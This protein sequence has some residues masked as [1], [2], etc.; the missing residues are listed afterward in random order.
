[1]PEKDP[2]NYTFIT[3][4]WVIFLSTWGGL[5]SFLRK[6]K[7]GEAKASNIMELIGELV[8]SSFAGMITFFLCQ[9]AGFDGVT[10]AALVGISGHMGT[11]A[12]FI[13]EQIIEKWLRSRAP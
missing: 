6:V 7:S 12:V 10:T 4:G 11:R 3:Y 5:V 8:T 2:A 1:M 13:M 9:K